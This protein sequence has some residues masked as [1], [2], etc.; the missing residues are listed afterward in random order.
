[1]A[2]QL[3]AADRS[4]SRCRIC[5]VS[6]MEILYRVWQD[7]GQTEARLAYEQCLSLPLV[8]VHEDAL[9]LEKALC[10]ALEASAGMSSPG[11]GW[12]RLVAG[13]EGCAMGQVLHGSAT[14]TAAVRRAIQHSQES[15]RALA[16]R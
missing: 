7:E 15:L 6:L 5:F 1:M 4:G 11:N 2:R 13:I 14:T 16:K 9:L 3:S 8:I 12:C 10:K